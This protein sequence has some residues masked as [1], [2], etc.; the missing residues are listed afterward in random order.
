MTDI[1]VKLHTDT[2][3]NK[4]Y[5]TQ[6][7]EEHIREYIDTK[8]LKLPDKFTVTIR[9]PDGSY[10]EINEQNPIIVSCYEYEQSTTQDDL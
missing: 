10:A 5:T 8:G 2:T 3:V 4:H 9:N 1:H 7:T 6:L